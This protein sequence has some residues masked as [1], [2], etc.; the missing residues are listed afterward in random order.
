MHYTDKEYIYIFHKKEKAF[1]QIFAIIAD[2]LFIHSYKAKDFENYVEKKK[3]SE[4]K[5]VY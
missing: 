1:I 5:L 4:F 2:I 3:Y